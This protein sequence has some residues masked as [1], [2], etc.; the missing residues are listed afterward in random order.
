MFIQGRKEITLSGFFVRLLND[1]SCLH[2]E[3]KKFCKLQDS[4][5][6]GEK[7]DIFKRGLDAFSYFSMI[8]S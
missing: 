4:G 5:R 7:I 3:R 1:F 8:F 2:F 6:T